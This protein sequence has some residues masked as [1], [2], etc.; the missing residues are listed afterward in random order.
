MLMFY[1]LGEVPPLDPTKPPPPEPKPR[2]IELR[3][4]IIFGVIAGFATSIGTFAFNLISRKR[5]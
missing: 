2:S 4:A 1:R 3:D 5:S